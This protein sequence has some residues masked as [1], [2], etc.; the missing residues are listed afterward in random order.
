MDF[1]NPTEAREVATEFRDR[2]RE[3]RAEADTAEPAHGLMLRTLARD[4]ERRA[5]SLELYVDSMRV[6]GPARQRPPSATASRR[7]TAGGRWSPAASRA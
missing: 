4:Y 2:A 7:P 1:E 5:T 3:L 6:A